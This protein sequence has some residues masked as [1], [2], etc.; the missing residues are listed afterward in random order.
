MPSKHRSE[1]V[2]TPEFRVSYPNVFQA[3]MNDLSKKMEFSMTCL[4][5]KGEGLEKIKGVLHEL[6]EERWPGAK[7]QGIIS[8]KPAQGQIR[9]PLKDQGIRE[10]T[11]DQTQERYMP[12]AYEK[13]CMM[14]E[15]K[16]TQRPGLVDSD[17][18]PII[19]AEGFYAGC[20]AR[21]TLSAFTYDQA[22]N[23][24][25]S[26]SLQNIQKLRDGDPLSGRSK[27]E[28]DFAPIVSEDSPDEAAGVM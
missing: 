4:F 15:T 27:P 19:D 28:D 26:L 10:K 25:V 2:T 20:Y 14:I 6:I 11:N 24:G 21:C 7:A 18:Q 13:G 12:G 23:R 17:M 1:K 8:P 16:N 3:R 5:K 9:W 22:G